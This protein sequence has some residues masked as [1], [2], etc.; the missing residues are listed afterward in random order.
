MTSAPPGDRS[1]AHGA[2]PSAH[3]DRSS[4]HGARPSAHGDR[5]WAPGVLA[6]APG[7]RP[8]AQIGV[9]LPANGFDAEEPD[10]APLCDARAVATYAR[11][12]AVLALALTAIAAPS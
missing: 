5:T 6:P 11:T 12:S 9:A 7:S 4:A 1:S 3:G 10:D 8:S 2:R